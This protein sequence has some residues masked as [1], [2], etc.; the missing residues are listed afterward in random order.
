M[1]A[2]STTSD[3]TGL[4][5]IDRPLRVFAFDPSRGTTPTNVVTLRVP[6]EK[7][8][9][10]PIGRYVAVIDE[11]STLSRTYDPVDLEDV[12]HLRH[13][14]LAP[15]ELDFGFHQQMAYAVASHTIQAFE[16]ALGREIRWPWAKSHAGDDIGDKLQI[17]PHAMEVANA[18]YT[19]GALHFGYF[20]GEAGL[21]EVVYTTLSYDLVAHETVHPLI[22]A[23]FPHSMQGEM[24][25]ESMAFHEGF[26][27]LIALL[28]HFDF[29]DALIDAVIRTRGRIWELAMAPDVEP[30][31]REAL[32]QAERASTNPLLEL[33]HQFGHAL[34]L[35]TAIRTVLSSAPDPNAFE[36]T[37]E[38]H[39]K[40]ANFV[41]AIFDALF[42]V[43][44]RR[45]RD[46]LQADGRNGPN[47]A[48]HPDLARRLAA[49]AANTAR[50]FL[51]ICIRALDYCPPV[52]IQIG[53]FLRALVT[54]DAELVPTDE[55]RLRDAVIQSFG[56][57]GIGAEGVV[58]YSEEGIRWSRA[59]P[60]LPPCS[61]LRMSDWAAEQNA[62][63]LQVYAGTHREALGLAPRLRPRIDPASVHISQRVAPSGELLRE[64]IAQITQERSGKEGGSTLVIDES[65][66]LKYVIAK[67]L[68]ETRSAEPESRSQLD[69][70]SRPS[71]QPTR[72]PSERRPLKIFAFDPTRGSRFGNHLTVS[73]PYEPLEQGPIGRQIA[74]IDYDASNDRYYEAVNLEGL[75][76]VLGGGIDPTDLDPK[77]HQQMVYAVAAAA[78]ERFELG[79]GR[80]IV[81]PWDQSSSS[82]LNSRL[83]MHPH[84]MQ[85]ANAYYDRRLHGVL[86]GYFGASEDASGTNL[87]GQIVYTCL[88]HDVVVHETTHA[89]LDSVHPYLLERTS[90]DAPAFHEAFADI[91][92]LLQHF[93]FADALLETIRRSGGRIHAAQFTVENGST[94][95]PIIGAEASMSNPLVE[96]ARQFGEALGTRA[97]LRSALGTPR[98]QRALDGATEAHARGA[99]LV[100]AVFDAFFSVYV[101]RSEDLLRLAHSA[102]TITP[103][104]DVHPD[105]AARL[106]R[107]AT[108][109]ARRFATMCVRALD[110]L[111]PVDVA[112]GDFLRALITADAEAE[113]RDPLGYRAAL[114]DAF[115]SRG[116][117]PQGVASLSEVALNWRP[118]EGMAALRC[119]ELNPDIS[120]PE[121]AKHNAIYLRDFARKH[122]RELGFSPSAPIRVHRILSVASRRVDPHGIVRPEFHVQLGQRRT[123][124]IDPEAAE[125]GTFT[126]RGGATAVL[127]ETGLVRYLVGKGLDNKDRL[128]AQQRYLQQVAGS[129]P[130]A[131]YR[132]RAVEA[133]NIASLHRGLEE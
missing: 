39:Q 25:S 52:D 32:I 70:R 57:R 86:F 9:P 47:D 130:A 98:D 121:T 62:E 103:S 21:K 131:A 84:A 93:S 51:R 49:E 109:T 73:V 89:L 91:M 110:Y 128:K 7:L 68:A 4:E 122:A 60:T 16:Q 104:G 28:Q 100:A 12:D 63:L 94:P 20:E 92:A 64:I 101:R 119:E 114:V 120:Q 22:H 79:L 38:P 14:G 108:E 48:L 55:W 17:Y 126:F 40:G 72:G 66:A 15:S 19:D 65:G 8:L 74:V 42:S 95:I 123:E 41:A 10:G 96:L 117:Y 3:L 76:V 106:A 97:A 35:R 90:I 105:L 113:P 33:G 56:A 36:S 78:I 107:E 124:P 125:V 116:I 129:A 18:Y 2:K 102:G 112:F 46:L 67:P 53:E 6:Y 71:R 37:D 1:R 69:P 85:E 127:D 61:G 31:G 58:A 50:Q 88:S 115:S 24:T 83:L 132:G 82:P 30:G 99:I 80:S 111:P 87:P 26:A 5:P 29:D 23:V 27:D 45:T 13:G 118:T 54:S 59:D 75:G 11:D 34:N 43:Y 81:W 77:F 133:L 44:V